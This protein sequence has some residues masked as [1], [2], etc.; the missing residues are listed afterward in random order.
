MTQDYKLEKLVWDDR[1]FDQMGWHDATIYGFAF[2]P[3]E[4]ELSLDIDYIFEWV[5]PP[6]GEEFF[7]FWVAP[8]T[9]VFQN[10]YDLHVEAEL[11]SVPAFEIDSISRHDPRTPKNSEFIA[12]YLEWRWTL[13]CHHG[14]VS[15]RSVGFKQY[16]RKA[17]VF[18]QAQS[19]DF[20]E[21]G[22]FSFERAYDDVP[23]SA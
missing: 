15:F 10:V 7:R 12:R 21:R 2:G 23:R 4:F 3:G 11:Y 22:G 17:P 8:C 6:Q 19:P 14:E 20:S 1:D 18:T 9:L 13:D 16:V 5:R